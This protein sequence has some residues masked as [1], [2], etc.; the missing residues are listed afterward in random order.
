MNSWKSERKNGCYNA[1]TILDQHIAIRGQQPIEATGSAEP[2]ADDEYEPDANDAAEFTTK[3]QSNSEK[4]RF[5]V[6]KTS[7]YLFSVAISNSRREVDKD[8][9]VHK[10]LKLRRRRLSLKPSRI[11]LMF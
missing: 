4:P 5:K 1:K 3:M 11:L 8:I 7:T 2:D 6:F 10:S 9:V